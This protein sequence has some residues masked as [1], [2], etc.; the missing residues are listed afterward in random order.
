MTTSSIH[1]GFKT[2]CGSYWPIYSAGSV[3]N[4][5]ALLHF[6]SQRPAKSCNG[7]FGQFSNADTVDYRHSV[8]APR[9]GLPVPPH[10]AAFM[11]RVQALPGVQAWI[12][13]AMQ[14]KD[15]L[16]FEEPYRLMP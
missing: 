11:Q 13:G 3:Q 9:Y 1:A 4:V 15:F 7:L 16:D 5:P 2:K 6:H 12:A 14:E 8:A 10:I